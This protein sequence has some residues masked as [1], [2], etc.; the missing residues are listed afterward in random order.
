MNA[1]HTSRVRLSSR[2]FF[3]SPSLPALSAALLLASCGGGASGEAGMQMPPADVSVAQVVSRSIVDW[4]EFTGRVQAVDAVEIR[5]RV[6]GYL[7]GVHFKEGSLVKKGDLLFTIDPREYEAAVAVARANLVRAE[8]RIALAQQQLERADMLIA[9]R[10]ISQEEYDQRQTEV[11]QAVADRG[12]AK[13][14]LDQ[15]ELN[16]SFS[17]ITAPI[18]GRIGAALIKPGNLVAPG[19]P[20]LTTLVSVDPI[21]VTF[22]ADESLYLRYQNG[23]LGSGEALSSGGL[24]MPVD[25]GLASDTTFPYHGRLDFIDNRLDPACSRT[26]TASTC[27]WSART[28]SPSAVTSSSA[29]AWTAYAS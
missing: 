10:A 7:A 3:L 14:Q 12:G 15:A 19:D 20:V 21:Y 22:E 8:T 23:E 13:A 25:V 26:R 1:R 6:A 17:R 5:P 4:N 27:T 16:L 24:E 9:A 18:S 11:Q 29:A 2:R 28:I